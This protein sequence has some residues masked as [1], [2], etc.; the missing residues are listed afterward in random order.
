M[1]GGTIEDAQMK[2]RLV[3]I[4]LQYFPSWPYCLTA[5][6]D[7]EEETGIQPSGKKSK[8]TWLAQRIRRFFLRKSGTSGDK[9]KLK[10]P[11]CKQQL[12]GCISAQKHEDEVVQEIGLVEQ[13]NGSPGLRD[14]QTSGKTKYV[15]NR[16]HPTKC[17][18]SLR[19]LC[20]VLVD[21]VV[22]AEWR[23]YASVNWQ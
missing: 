8:K 11:K 1:C 6:N 22:K 19:L 9:K 4:I 7:K 23:V 16:V 5:R 3:S 13:L 20:L 17:A 14:K 10:S 21:S 2:E 12:F 15:V 18:H